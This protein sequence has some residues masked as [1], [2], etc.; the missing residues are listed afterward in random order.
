M[1]RS[2]PKVERL[3]MVPLFRDLTGTHLQK[4]AR[5]VEE[6]SVPSGRKVVQER[7]F[8]ESGGAAFFLILE[9]SADVTV[10]GKRI[11]RLR[12]GDSFGELSLLDGKARSATVTATGPLTLYRIRSW[13]FRD[14]VKSEPSI[15]LGLLQTLADR[16]RKL[17]APARR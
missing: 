14:L 5:A 16:L 9:G 13:D 6:V 17:E 4:V 10:R 2:V 8:R 1:A 11:A 12:A 7:S 15:A 3:R